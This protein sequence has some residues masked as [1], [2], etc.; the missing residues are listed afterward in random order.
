MIL[1]FYSNFLAAILKM[2]SLTVIGPY[3]SLE[4]VN[5]A[6]YGI[7]SIRMRMSPYSTNDA[8][9]D[10]FIGFVSEMESRLVDIVGSCDLCQNRSIS[11]L[12]YGN[13]R[14]LAYFTKKIDITFGGHLDFFY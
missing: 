12:I 14:N 10:L 3:F 5:F 4:T 7:F 6:F 1:F 9:M 2:A 11:M 13:I 8:R